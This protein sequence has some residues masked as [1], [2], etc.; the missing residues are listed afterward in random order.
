[1]TAI[2]RLPVAMASPGSSVLPNSM[3]TA[4]NLPMNAAVPTFTP[5]RAAGTGLRT[6]M[7]ATAA[8]L[9]AWGSVQ[10]QP[11][12]APAGRVISRA[13]TEL[14]ARAEGP[15]CGPRVKVIITSTNPKLFEGD[16]P[17]AAKFFTNARAGHSLSCP[18][19]TRMVAQ[20]KSGEKIMF[21][22]MADQST[23][24]EALILGSSA[25]GAEDAA[26]AGSGPTP[27]SVL[28]SSPSFVVAKDVL[29]QTGDKYLCLAGTSLACEVIVKFTP[30]GADKVTIAYRQALSGGKST[31]AVTS[32]AALH[33]GFFCADPNSANVV[34]EDAQMSEDAK[35]DYAA[36]LLDRVKSNGEICTGFSGKIEA[37]TAFGFDASG[38]SVDKSR[39]VTLYAKLPGFNGAR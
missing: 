29:A 22:A 30:A 26:L 1:M 28:R 34:V 9:P 10:A 21:T 37:L 36:Q 6:V 23:G 20:G 15:A 14:E 27:K 32:T 4:V 17:V 3:E 8:L 39:G 16:I 31:A 25:A 19:M 12:S 38:K 13:G 35:K 18:Q 7:L 5:A 11:A 33:D 24:W 2:D